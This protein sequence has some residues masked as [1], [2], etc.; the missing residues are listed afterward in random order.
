MSRTKMLVVLFAAVALWAACTMADEPV[1][2]T[3]SGRV[4]DQEHALT[5]FDRIEADDAIV[6]DV[7]QGEAFRV[8]LHADE[9]LAP[10]VQVV[11]QDD[12]LKIGLK[13]GYNYNLV[14]VPTT[15]VEVTMPR[16]RGLKLRRACNLTLFSLRFTETLH[17]DLAE[18][19]LLMGHLQAGDVHI[20]VAGSAHAILSGAGQNLEVR[21]TGGA[22][23]IEL[24]DFAVLD[25]TIDVSNSTVTVQPSGRLD[26]KARASQIYYLGHPTLGTVDADG[27]SFVLAR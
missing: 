13:D 10:Y 11:K 9:N 15:H 12:T 19:S 1:T 24:G 2:I 5:G 3:G 8:L 20:D 22:A 27:A 18:G 17:V 6:V 26:V 14:R 21:V 4:V 16:L 23:L 25:A 7:H